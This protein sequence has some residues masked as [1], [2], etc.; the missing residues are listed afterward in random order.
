MG[1]VGC[2]SIYMRGIPEEGV[3]MA[4]VSNFCAKQNKNNPYQPPCDIPIICYN[5]SIE[6]HNAQRVFL[7]LKGLL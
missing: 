1:G 2:I 7:T 5:K 6:G 4:I 3:I